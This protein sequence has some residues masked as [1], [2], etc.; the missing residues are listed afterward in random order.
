MTTTAAHADIQ[1][2]IVRT[3]MGAQVL[4]GVGMAAGMAVGALLAEDISG[5]RGVTGVIVDRMGYNPAGM[6]LGGD[7]V[8]HRRLGRDGIAVAKGASLSG[9]RVAGTG[10]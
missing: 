2:R 3:L 10:C 5:R 1:P 4:G 7:R 8:V 6:G 9:F